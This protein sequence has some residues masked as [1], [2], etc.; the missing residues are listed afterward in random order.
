MVERVWLQRW[1][2]GERF[3]D[4]PATAR[5]DRG[6]FSV[7]EPGW[8][9]GPGL[10]DARTQLA[11]PGLVNTHVH[12]ARAGFFE[13]E[14][15]PLQLRQITNNLQGALRAGVTTVADM[16]CTMPMLRAL[17]A[18][19]ESDPLAGPR[20][21]GAGPILT[22]PEG[23]PF[24][25]V[26]PLWRHSEAVFAVA[27]ERTAR[28]AVEQTL[29]GGMDHLKVAVM[30]EDFARHP[31]PALTPRA[32]GA[33]VDEARRAER[34]VYAHAHSLADYRVSL[35]AGVTGLMHSCFEPLGRDDIARIVDSGAAVCPTLWAYD[36]TC[37]V[38]DCS[39][40]LRADLQR[41][42][43]APLRRSWQRFADAYAAS[44]PAFPDESTLP[45]VSKD[46]ARSAMRVASANLRLLHEAR[47]PIVFGT[48][49]SFGVALLARPCDELYAMHEAGMDV[50]AC[51]RSATSTAAD[52]LGRSELGRI[53][54]GCSADFVLTSPALADDLRWLD[55]D[56][57]ATRL[58]VY[59]A[60]TL[61]PAQTDRARAARIARAYLEGTGLTLTRT[62]RNWTAAV[63]E[64]ALGA[65]TS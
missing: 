58:A 22:A 65:S 49:A 62:L 13:A 44:G 26:S 47:V 29:G 64:R 23:Y 52:L 38:G 25:W 48:D 1:F 36:S 12:V 15:P 43:E 54:P 17:R 4:D 50:T 40:H 46:D 14:E 53:A 33:I 60:G 42:A 28:R 59:V 41:H 31:L 55:G 9:G 61:V 2:D 30:H 35:A 27:D 11:I 10:L 8:Q 6:R 7:I 37:Q 3:R 63:V 20:I 39:V 19:T 5:V 21:V 45:G 57:P 51:L 34:R 56:R 18:L 32:A 24:N 16:G